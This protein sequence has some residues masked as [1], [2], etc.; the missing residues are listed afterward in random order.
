MGTNF[1][2]YTWICIP[3]AV[4]ATATARK[5]LIVLSIAPAMIFS[6]YLTAEDLAHATKPSASPA[7][8]K[9]LV[10][11]L[12][13]LPDLP[14]CRLE[15]VQ[16]PQVHTA[17]NTLIS[18]VALAGGWETQQ[19]HTLNGILEDK[20]HLTA[21]TYKIWLDNNAVC[22]VAY[23]VHDN[24]PNPEYHLVGSG[25]LRYLH[26]VSQD[27]PWV[28]YSVADWTPIVALPQVLVDTTQASLTISVP[29]ACRFAVRVRYSK[30]LTATSLGG[31]HRAEVSDDGT[32][33]TV[34]TTH[35][36]GMYVLSG[37]IG[38]RLR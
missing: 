6:T 14:N 4:V 8:Y 5:L 9:P 35:A 12:D 13:G 25:T 10:R 24:T 30:L 2:R 19:A 22:Y 31:T 28:L 32:G 38:N 27:G 34:V 33:W 7:Y 36:P 37:D 29:C 20:K 16:D 26:R 3:A 23:N 1:N 17:A 21:D 11:Q 18:Y 15:V